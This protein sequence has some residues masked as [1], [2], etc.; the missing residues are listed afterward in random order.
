[1]NTRTA[2]NVESSRSHAIFSISIQSSSVDQP[3]VM[4]TGRLNLVDLSG[5]ENLKRSG[6]T[7]E[8]AREAKH[9]NRGLLA[10]GRVIH[11]KINQRAYVPFRDSKLTELLEQS[12]G[13]N[14]LTT[15]ILTISPSH[16]EMAETLSTL[17]YASNAK[18]IKWVIAACTYVRTR[19]S[20]E[21]S[22]RFLFAFLFFYSLH[23]TKPK[24]DR[25]ITE[26]ASLRDSGKSTAG[27]GKQEEEAV[28]T[29]QVRPWEGRIPIRKPRSTLGF[30][31]E[32]G[33]ARMEVFMEERSA[34]ALS[35]AG[36]GVSAAQAIAI[37]KAYGPEAP[38]QPLRRILH[39]PSGESCGGEIFFSVP[40]R[41]LLTHAPI[42]ITIL[43]RANRTVGE[44]RALCSIILYE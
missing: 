42:P 12:L 2:G 38:P 1:M 36:S 30:I 34:G 31:S 9:I 20:L 15:M 35:A 7:N 43:A 4:R 5:S 8:R 3:G 24:A 23:R 16:F 41:Q 25:K 17:S 11:A 14:S 40:E 32:H 37:A 13:G 18:E 26:N 22:Q 27:T 6:S 33:K 44:R 39:G 21:N 28:P 10:L 19:L 29:V